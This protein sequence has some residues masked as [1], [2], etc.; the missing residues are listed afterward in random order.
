MTLLDK[1]RRKG[2]VRRRKRGKAYFYAPT[3]KRREVLNF[4]VQE[5]ANSY[6]HGHRGLLK[7][8]LQPSHLARTSAVALAAAT[9]QPGLPVS[10]LEVELL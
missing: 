8:F 9:R 2:T 4:L 1:M 5:F 3:V 6:C 10:D 7:P